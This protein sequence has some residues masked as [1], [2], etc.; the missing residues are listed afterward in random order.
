MNWL[1]LLI[2]VFLTKNFTSRKKG[3]GSENLLSLLKIAANVKESGVLDLLNSGEPLSRILSGNFPVEKLL[4]LFSAFSSEKSEES[5]VE[6][7]PAPLS[8]ELTGEEMGHVLSELL[9]ENYLVT[10]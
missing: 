3:L 4:E 9:N 7:A 2:L 8:E 6:R 5:R 1:P 10:D